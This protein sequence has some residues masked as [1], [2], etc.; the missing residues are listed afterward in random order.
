M[1]IKLLI[2]ALLFIMIAGCS[3]VV[4]VNST[5]PVTV[6]KFGGNT[7]INELSKLFCLCNI[8]ITQ[9]LSVFQTLISTTNL[10]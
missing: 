6:S 8:N 3:T 4:P 10:D 2:S 9:D 7:L 1:K 5:L